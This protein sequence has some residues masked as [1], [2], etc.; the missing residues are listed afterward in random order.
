MQIQR[1]ELLDALKAVKAAV[2]TRDTPETNNR[3]EFRGN[4]VMGISAEIVITYPLSFSV[5]D[6]DITVLYEELVTLLAN[7]N[8]EEI[9][10]SVKKDKLIV[11]DADVRVSF[12]LSPRAVND[13]VD[14]LATLAKAVRKN[15]CGIEEELLTAIDVCMQSTGKEKTESALSCVHVHG[16]FVDAS[17]DYQI[18]RCKLSTPFEGDTL[19][20]AKMCRVVLDFEPE[21]YHLEKA[22]SIF[23]K[24]IEGLKDRAYLFIRAV[25]YHV[26]DVEPLLQVKGHKCVFPPTLAQKINQIGILSAGDFALEKNILVKILSGMIQ[27]STESFYGKAIANV[28]SKEIEWNGD[29]TAF[30][31]NP[32]LL[33][34]IASTAKSMIIS[35]TCDRILVKD[36]NFTHVLC[37]VPA[38]T[39]PTD[40]E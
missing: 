29:P 31:T 35:K 8:S 9:D 27:I 25:D 2:P 10:I 23:T 17:D 1:L 6:E 26:E 30:Y 5:S 3:I 37:A 36:G 20:P 13:D 7:S 18:S 32:Y 21:S 33:S 39:E 4:Y 11:V 16:S 28:S 38:E 19:I 12:V 14:H 24:T 15:C 22:W 40:Q 34:R